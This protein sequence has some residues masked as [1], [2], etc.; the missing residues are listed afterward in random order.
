MLS[1]RNE[2]GRRTVD[3]ASPY[4]L[5]RYEPL[6]Y[7][8]LDRPIRQLIGCV[9]DFSIFLVAKFSRP[10]AGDG[11]RIGKLAQQPQVRALPGSSLPGESDYRLLIA[12]LGA[13]A[14][15]SRRTRRSRPGASPCRMRRPP[16]RDWRRRRYGLTIIDAA[17]KYRHQ[18]DFFV[19]KQCGIN[20]ESGFIEIAKDGSTTLFP[21]A[22]QWRQRHVVRGK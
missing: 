18:P 19:A 7:I 6:K 10:D 1:N 16:P 9:K 8:C 21:H 20:C 4:W 5:A 22:R 12:K 17:M 3:I 13:A 2:I 14:G 11:G 15:R